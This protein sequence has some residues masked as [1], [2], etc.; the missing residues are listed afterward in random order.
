M[1]DIV[2]TTEETIQYIQPDPIKPKSNLRRKADFATLNRCNTC[3]CILENPANLANIGT[4]I[5]NVNS[6]GIGKLYVVDGRNLFGNKSW[7]GIRCSHHLMEVS[8]SAIK[9]TYVKIFKT[10]RECFE[11]LEA[12]NF[13]S[14]CT[15]PHIIGK[16]N[17]DLKEGTFTDK[18]L[19]VWFGNEVTGISEEVTLKCKTCIQI[20]M[21]GIIES[22]NLATCTGIVL[23]EISNQRRN[24][25]ENNRLIKPN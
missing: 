11:Y 7:A 8:A 9:W 24:F 3:I 18:K 15:S 10:T 1:E 14:V 4:V 6:L 21:F 16:D 19:A 5:R 22:L 20:G 17:V 25:T 23:Y 13:V 12:K 2:N